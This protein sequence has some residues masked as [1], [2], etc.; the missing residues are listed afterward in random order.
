MITS[1]LFFPDKDF[2]QRPEDYGLSYED[3]SAVTSDGVRLHGWYL[4]AWPSHATVVMF[5]GNAGNISHRLFKT[6]PLVK[7]GISFLLID[8]RGFGR[9]E[10]E[11]GKG[12][13]LFS[14]GR[15]ALDWLQKEK[16]VAPSGVFLFGESIGSAPALQLASELPVKGVILESPFTT[17]K[18]LAR[19]HYPFAPSLLLGSFAFDNLSNIQKMKAPLLIIHGK[20]DEICPFRMG[21]TLFE[22]ASGAKEIFVIPSGGHNDLVDVAG[23]EYFSRIRRFVRGGGLSRL[24]D[25]VAFENQVGNN[26][27]GDKERHGRLPMTHCPEMQGP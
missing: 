20:A 22:S 5:H 8:Y 27:D 25:F 4:P 19:K 9:S 10:G 23:P 18:E 24:L 6:A 3:V 14:D 16:G 11:I 13:D 15:A 7:E 26:R 1:F 21:E 17:L 2:W 12:E